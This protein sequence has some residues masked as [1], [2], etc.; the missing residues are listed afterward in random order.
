MKYSLVLALCLAIFFSSCK[1]DPTVPNEQEVITTLT[2]TLS[3]FG[4]GDAVVF[5]FR[6]IDGDGGDAPVITAGN[7]QANTT[8]SGAITLQNEQAEPV[9]DITIEIA[10][11]V[12]DHQFFFETALSGLTIKYKDTDSNNNPVGLNTELV[13]GDA[14]TGDLTITLLHEP[15]KNAANVSSGDKTNAGGATDIEVTFS[16]TVE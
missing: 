14:G 3:P 10:E 12:D 1:K 5:T 2:Y 4:G 6:D 15:D 11:E 16:V 7:L 8:Y 9:D 13:T